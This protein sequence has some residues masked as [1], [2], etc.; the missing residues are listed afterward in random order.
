MGG[1]LP[2]PT[3]RI[4]SNRAHARVFPLRS[5]PR[6]DSKAESHSSL[7]LCSM[8]SKH[9]YSIERIDFSIFLLKELK[10]GKLKMK[11]LKNIKI[12]K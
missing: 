7:S 4:I 10:I 12:K 6:L 3:P 1:P 11:K 5:T 2:P 8:H 9:N